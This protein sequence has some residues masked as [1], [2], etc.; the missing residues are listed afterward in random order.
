MEDNNY[1]Y[2]KLSDQCIGLICDESLIC[3]GLNSNLGHFS[4]FN[5]TFVSLCGESH[6]FVS[7]C[8]GDRCSMTVSD[9]DCD[10]SRRPGAEDWGW[11]HKS[12]TR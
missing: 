4:C 5:F 12:G 10:R 11:S 9:E 7:W 3:H 2:E 1:K 6:L 8:V